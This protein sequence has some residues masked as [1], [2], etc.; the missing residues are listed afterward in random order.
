MSKAKDLNEA[1]MA[2]RGIFGDLMKNSK[3][4]QMLSEAELIER[5]SEGDSPKKGMMK[6]RDIAQYCVGNSENIQECLS[7]IASHT[8]DV[9]NMG[10]AYTEFEGDMDIEFLRL[11][12]VKGLLKSSDMLKRMVRKEARNFKSQKRRQ[13]I[14]SNIKD[15]P[16][17]EKPDELTYQRLQK[18][19]KMIGGVPVVTGCRNSLLNLETILTMDPK[20]KNRISWSQLHQQSMIDG[21]LVDDLMLT[22]LQSWLAKSYG[23]EFRDQKNINKYVNLIAQNNK[24]HPVQ[25]WLDDLQWDQTYRLKDLATDVFNCKDANSMNFVGH[26]AEYKRFGIDGQATMPQIAFIRAF[27]AA[28][29]RSSDPG[30]KVDWMPILISKQGYGKSQSIRAIAHDPSW[31][32]NVH[33][34]VRKKDAIT[35]CLG[36]WI[37]EYPECETLSKAGHSNVKQ[38]LSSAIDRI[39]LNYAIYSKD[40]PR[41]CVFWGSTNKD[42]LELLNDTTGSRRFCAFRVGKINLQTLLDKSFVEQLWAEAMHYYTNLAEVWYFNDT[43]DIARDKL[44]KKF[45]TLDVWEERIDQII[46][47]RAYRWIDIQLKQEDGEEITPNDIRKADRNLIFTVQ[48]VVEDFGRLELSKISSKEMRRITDALKHLG[49]IKVSDN[50]FRQKIVKYKPSKKY[51]DSL[52]DI[53]RIRI[54]NEEALRHFEQN[55]K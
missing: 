28:C 55:E 27:I 46:T 42:Q 1:R 54:Q 3:P 19:T 10:K 40:I 23:V 38:F 17:G 44:N 16:W 47:E 7:Y 12:A 36:K 48:D 6:L 4:M 30:C 50:R 45:R 13:S 15:S 26:I 52:L 32:A 34:D 43:E 11:R 41:T 9:T 39:Q 35:N 53:E 20:W 33:F 18:T 14:V 5:E 8:S 29:A 49:C 37:V 24:V 25:E 21:K 51:L 31:F 2:K 22:K